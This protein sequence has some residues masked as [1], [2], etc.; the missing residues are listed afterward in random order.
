MTTPLLT[1]PLNPKSNEKLWQNGGWVK[2]LHWQDFKSFALNSM[3][4]ITALLDQ[5]L[6][7]EKL[8]LQNLENGNFELVN[9]L[10]SASE[11]YRFAVNAFNGDPKLAKIITGWC[12]YASLAWSY[13]PRATRSESDIAGYICEHAYK[14]AGVTPEEAAHHEAFE[15]LPIMQKVTDAIDNVPTAFTGPKIAEPVGR[16]HMP[17]HPKF[18]KLTI[19]DHNNYFNY[20][21][22]DMNFFMFHP[23]KYTVI[24]HLSHYCQVS[25][26]EL[27]GVSLET[28]Q[29]KD[30]PDVEVLSQ[31]QTIR[32]QKATHA[33][34]KS[35]RGDT[36]I[37][38]L[39]FYGS[40]DYFEYA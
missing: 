32:L 11:Q 40:R 29:N 10:F 15:R 14:A 33:S 1:T 24:K 9:G 16:L 38:H 26:G 19:S 28:L 13:Q 20:C 34:V 17:L 2:C 8:Q 30:I 12:V 39:R 7:D 3:A 5:H 6:G 18:S 25:A 36:S 27:D 21:F 23:S 4:H 37:T 31:G 22:A 35:V